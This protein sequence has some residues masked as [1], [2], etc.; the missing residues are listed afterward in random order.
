MLISMAVTV[1]LS[2]FITTLSWFIQDGEVSFRSASETP[3][4][5]ISSLMLLIGV[6]VI[7]CLVFD[8]E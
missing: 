6:W 1:M 7:G 5:I 2:L 8:E 3:T 4:Q